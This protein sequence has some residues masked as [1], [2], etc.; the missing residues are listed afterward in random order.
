MSV[1][2]FLEKFGD[3]EYIP[4]KEMDAG[5]AIGGSGLAFAYYFLNAISDGSVRVGISKEK[6]VRL[7]SQIAISAV[8]CLNRSDDPEKFFEYLT[9]GT[10]ALAGLELI[11]KQ[12]L[13]THIENSIK[14]AFD[15]IVEL[16]HVEI[17][18]A[19]PE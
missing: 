8:E 4:E 2:L 11:K 7:V 12:N 15:R 1:E 18:P 19:F 6:S 3:L 5:C 13:S 9:M 10:P 14:A 16:A 17:A